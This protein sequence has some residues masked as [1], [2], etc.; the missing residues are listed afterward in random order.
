MSL[1][2]A[3]ELLDDLAQTFE[4]DWLDQVR[5]ESRLLRA[6]EVFIHAVAAQGDAAQS[7]IAR[8]LHHEVDAVSIGQTDVAHD[9]I[10]LLAGGLL[11]RDPHRIGRRHIMPFLAQQTRQHF[12]RRL[13]IFDDEQTIAARRRGG[14]GA[15]RRFVLRCG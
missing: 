10:E 9:E 15:V 2:G 12:E 5:E 11:E 6:R 14:G 1:S 7:V 4:V 8:Q 13:M 3:A